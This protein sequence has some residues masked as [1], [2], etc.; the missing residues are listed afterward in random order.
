MFQS[1]QYLEQQRTLVSPRLRRGL[2]TLV[3]WLVG[4]NC[5]GRKSPEVVSGSSD[6]SS[7][8]TAASSESTTN[9]N[10]DPAVAEAAALAQQAGGVSRGPDIPQE[11]SG[12]LLRA[13]EQAGEPFVDGSGVCPAWENTQKLEVLS[14]AYGEL[15]ACS[16]EVFPKY[17]PADAPLGE[18]FRFVVGA[19][20]DANAAEVVYTGRARFRETDCGMQLT[21]RVA[22][23][24]FPRFA[25]GTELLVHSEHRQ[26]EAPDLVAEF[27]IVW[28]TAGNVL[29]ANCGGYS[30]LGQG[31][32]PLPSLQII[33]DQ[34]AT[35]SQNRGF[36]FNF[37]GATLQTDNGSCHLGP[38]SAQCCTLWGA[39]YRASI[40]GTPHSAEQKRM[41]QGPI[42]FG[43]YV[44]VRS[45]VLALD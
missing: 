20:V 25:V 38:Y 19:A 32:C 18:P 16:E 40:S 37:A 8:S 41:A 11:E 10:V 27:A 3:Y 42:D 9:T 36:L 22:S 17:Y 31:F 15:A 2:A 14:H 45:D 33:P 23:G 21:F 12:S 1:S 43:N 4:V 7:A 5:G 34:A 39:D 6:T 26:R 13:C 24:A 30:S 44:L 35:C 28:D 29:W